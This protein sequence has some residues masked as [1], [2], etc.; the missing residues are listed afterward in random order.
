MKEDVQEISFGIQEFN[1]RKET[2]PICAIARD[3]DGNICLLM[4]RTLMEA[5]KDPKTAKLAKEINAGLWEVF[6][7]LS[8][9]LRPA[10][11]KKQ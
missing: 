2:V 8:E 5:S 6:E 1:F 10:N 4:S 11:G 9:Q 7:E 3:F